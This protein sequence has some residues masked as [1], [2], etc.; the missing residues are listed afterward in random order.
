[1][2]TARDLVLVVLGPTSQQGVE[3]GD[4]SLALAGAEA[5]DLLEGGELVLDAGRLIPGGGAQ[6]GT[7]AGNGPERASRDR[8]LEE[9]VASIVRREPYE[10]VEDWL[11]RRGQNLAAVYVGDLARPGHVAGRRHHGRP[12]ARATGGAGGVPA[13]SPDHRRAAE[14]LASAEPVLTVL[15]AT[16]RAADLPPG[17]DE[18][19][20]PAATVLAAVGDAVTALEAQRLRRGVEN[21]AYDNMWR[22]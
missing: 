9:A 17:T 3:Q 13:D 15:N 19:A 14:R 16:L 1:M 20:E 2:S 18:P 8:L 10:T 22:A 12:F 5:I 11:W 6:I 7:R 4:L 21:A